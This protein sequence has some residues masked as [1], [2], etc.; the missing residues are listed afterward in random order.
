MTEKTKL[1]VLFV[2]AEASPFAK[3]GGLADVAGSLPG[4][5]RRVGVDARLVLPCYHGIADKAPSP[6]RDGLSGL[7]AS[8]G[9]ETISLCVKSTML[10]DT[11]VSLIDIP[12]YFDRDKIYGYPDDP[13]RFAA[14]C[15]AVIAWLKA[16]DWTPDVIHC[17]DWQ[18][19]L[20]PALLKTV[21][22]E[23]QAFRD[24][25][26]VFSIHNLA[27]QGVVDSGMLDVF[28]LPWSEF[29][30]HK[31]EFFGNLNIM[32]GGILHADRVCTVS[33]TYA[34][35]ILTEEYGEGLHGFLQAHAHKLSGIVNGIESAVFDPATD[36]HICAQFSADTINARQENKRAL[37]VESGLQV[38]DPDMAAP[39]IGMV[40]RLTDQKGFDILIPA[41]DVILR[42][43]ARLVLL[44]D[45]DREIKAALTNAA[46]QS[47]GKMAVHLGFDE[48]LARRIYAGSD[49]FLMPSRFEPCGLGQMIAMRYGAAPIVRATGGLADTVKPFDPA[50]LL[51][52]GFVFHEYTTPALYG[53]VFQAMDLFHNNR[54]A[55]HT[56]I[57]IIMKQDVSWDVSA[58]AYAQLY[59]DAA[60]AHLQAD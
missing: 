56:L 44:G 24:T 4:A 55:W 34:R 32:K 49:M 45:G 14:F 12:Y 38:R 28:G 25:A 18:T 16:S 22:H 41:L 35:E 46:K 20:L 42:R 47:G 59:R 60:A 7:K 54:N 19:A 53:A 30:H 36:P 48:A 39:L 52:N 2:S 6:I 1:K 17:N 58:A 31:L 11:P 33:P 50:T 5:L 26:T 13:H 51:G 10:G 15:M 9:E 27:Y 40:A 23:D 21:Y 8:L 3:V 29:T 43:N 37:L 57:G